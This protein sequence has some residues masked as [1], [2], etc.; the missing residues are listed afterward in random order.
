MTQGTINPAPPDFE[1]FPERSERSTADTSGRRALWLTLLSVLTPGVAH[2]HAGRRR[3]ATVLVVFSGLIWLSVAFAV[4]TLDRE[5]LV[6]AA[7]RPAVLLL[8]ATTAIVVIPIWIL[9]VITSYN[10]VRPRC[11]SRR[12]A[13][14]GRIAVLALCVAVAAPPALVAHYAYSQYDLINAVFADGGG[15]RSSAAAAD[16]D[17]PAESAKPLPGVDRLNVLLLG[18]DAG[19]GRVGTRA[20]TMVLAS[21][22]Q[23]TGRTVLLSLPRN[24][25][26]APMPEGPPRAKYPEGYPGLLNGVYREGEDHDPGLMPGSPN[27]GA[28][29]LKGTISEVLGMPVHYF[30]QVNMQGFRELVDAMGGVDV[31]V[32]RSMPMGNTGAFFQPG[33][34]HLDG[35]QALW[36]ARSRTGASDYDRMER[37]RCMLST[38][39]E[40]ADPLTVLNHYHQVAAAAKDNFRTDIPADMLQDLA[41]LAN[42]VEPAGSVQFMPPLIEPSNP[43]FNHIRAVAKDTVA[44]SEAGEEPQATAVQAN[45][46][47]AAAC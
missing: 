33:P 44:Q 38:L 5:H 26:K 39:A 7:V 37:Q 41:S 42:K 32:A 4:L 47:V 13:R 3:T 34:Q 9:L 22:D 16:S 27:P 2:W 43:D 31:N 21:V 12:R 18:S 20:D 8:V 19:D 40:Q 28:D 1:P 35:A 10:A 14:T 23:D 46:R 45:S 15:S 17:D 6:G 30:A 29:L 11:L 25:Q 36:Y 24:L